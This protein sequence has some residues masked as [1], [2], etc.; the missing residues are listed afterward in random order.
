V[1]DLLNIS[2]LE[3]GVIPLHPAT[4]DIDHELRSVIDIQRPEAE[5]KGLTLE[6]EAPPEPTFVEADSERLAQVITN[7]VTNAINY[8]LAGGSVRVQVACPPGD[9][10]VSVHIIDTGVGIAP[11]HLPHIFQPFYRVVSHVDGTGLGLSIARQIVSMH[12]G[13]LTVASTPGTV[14][15]PAPSAGICTTR[16][17]M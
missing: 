11:E 8:T 14:S 9:D 2:R 15:M 10:M 17:T 1:E 7:L 4:L 16:R 5:R 6:Y 3:R 13:E 12:G